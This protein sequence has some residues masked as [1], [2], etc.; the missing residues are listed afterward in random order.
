MGIV[1]LPENVPG[2]GVMIMPHVSIN[3][4]RGRIFQQAV[5]DRPIGKK[6]LPLTSSTG[7]K[8]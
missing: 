1:T 5:R 3:S 4:R 8:I 7:R 6:T 2:T